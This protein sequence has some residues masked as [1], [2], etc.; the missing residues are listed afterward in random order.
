M[1]IALQNICFISAELQKHL[2]IASSTKAELASRAT[3]VYYKLDAA[4]AHIL[5]HCLHGAQ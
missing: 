3:A 4:A 2:P 5:P 1:P